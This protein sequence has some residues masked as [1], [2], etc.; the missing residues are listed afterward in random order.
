MSEEYY[1]FAVRLA[2]EFPDKYVATMAYSLRELPPQGVK[3]R[4]NMSVLYAPISCCALHNVT[5]KN[6][7]RRQEFLKIMRRYLS[8]TPHVYLYDY[9]PNFLTGLFVP[10]PQTANYIA[11]IPVYKE[12]GLKGF[13]A[14]GRK[15]FMQT[16]TSYYMLGK[17]LWDADADAEALKEDLYMT[18]S[19]P[20]AGPRIRTW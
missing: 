20:G 15:A 16:W 11:N 9:N 10:E 6:C 2:D 8:Q 14:E 5:H 7:W 1:D 19:D 12:V 17:L 18:G 4:K 3:L 13:Q